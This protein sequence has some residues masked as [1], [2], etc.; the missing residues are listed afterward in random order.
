MDNTNTVKTN[1]TDKSEKKGSVV[2]D[3]IF[4]AVLVL[5]PFLHLAFGVEF[6]DTAYSLGNY[7]NLDRMNLTWTIATFWANMLG[8][9]FTKLPFGSLWIG[10]KFY[11]TLVPVSGI[12]ISYLFLKKYIPRV[13]VFIGELLA[14][15]MFWCP[16]TI[17]YNYL[18]Y[19]LFTAAIVVLVT[20]LSK[21]CKWGLA[22]AGAILAFNVF[23][24]F[25]NITE[26]A[27]IL[28]VWLNT[29]VDRKKFVNGVLD[30]MICIG[31]FLAGI[32][33]NILVIGLN[34]GFSSIPA[35]VVSLFSM[36]GDNTGYKPTQMVLT[37]I[38][39][40]ATYYKSFI[41]LIGITV[42]CFAVSALMKRHYARIITV[43]AQ[44]V[45]YGLFLFWAYR[46]HVYTVRYSDYSSMYFWMVIFF[47]LGNIVTVWTILRKRNPKELKLI[48]MAVLVVMWITPLGSNNALYPS[49]NNLFIVAPAVIF[50]WW[51]EMFKGRNFYELLD[52]EA[53]N[54]MVASRITV[55]LLLISV[56]V[57]CSLF[58]IVFIFRD[59]G[60]PYDNHTSV[61]NNEVLKYM[62]TNPDRAALIEE[63]S[64]Y[65]K[66]HGLAGKEA[67]FYG[68]IPGLEYILKM[69][70]A[71]SHTW[72]DLGSF[73][74][75]DFRKDIEQLEKPPV[76]FINENVCE[77]IFNLDG[78]SSDK[79]IC[80]SEY[81]NANEYELKVRIDY[82]AI[83]T[84]R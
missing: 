10:M 62:H 54:T 16:T 76:I 48:A 35:M 81:M 41:F 39:A 27:L 30:T 57:H 56:F 17:L 84:A 65:V 49:I 71:I 42:I 60:F 50:M 79:E 11:T 19:L 67:I 64:A 20:S 70:C 80:L 25:P 2:W 37:I 9:G 40:Y 3:C 5:L 52:L 23:V 24:R 45:L 33:L 15:A 22:V 68:E 59:T 58:G 77:D 74:Y 63:L 34:Y 55:A 13:M 61:S 6:S 32:S 83:Y 46:N 44:F 47:I 69:P 43:V 72:P 29:R 26:I 1:K 75:E 82:I 53:K 78:G 18:T 28:V 8:K 14:I 7:E 21:D 51:N 66:N 4:L 36:T 73:S 12:V 38:R 31:G